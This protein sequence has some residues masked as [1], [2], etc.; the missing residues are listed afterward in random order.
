LLAP[1]R[2]D[3]EAGPAGAA[4]ASGGR[5]LAGDQRAEHRPHRDRG[6]A[7]GDHRELIEASSRIHSA[8]GTS[9]VRRGTAL[10]GAALTNQTSSTSSWQ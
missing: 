7:G 8:S 4:H 3:D 1:R 9:V 5:A 6:Q 2:S 10:M